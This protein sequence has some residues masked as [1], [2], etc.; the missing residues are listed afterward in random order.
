MTRPALLLALMLSCVVTVPS[1]LFAG[2]TDESFSIVLLPD[3][4]NYSEKFPDTYT[5]Q[6][7]WIRQNKETENIKF[8][9][10]LGDVVQTAAV[11]EQWVN[12]H[13]SMRL[14]DGILPYSMVPGNHDQVNEGGGPTRN[15]TLYNK[16]FGPDRFELESWYGGNFED[17]NDNN[18]V[19]FEAA[20][21]KFMVISLEFCPRNE[22]LRWAGNVAKKHPD[23]QVIMATHSY[24]RSDGRDTGNVKSY[25][26]S[27]NTGEELWEKF[28]SKH[29]NVFMVVCGH[30]G[31]SYN[32]TST[33]E[34]GKPVHEILV[35]YQNLENGGDGWLRVLEFTPSEN[36]V[37]AKTYS[38]VVN[39]FKTEGAHQYELDFEMTR[40]PVAPEKEA[41][42][43][44]IP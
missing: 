7:V 16:Y 4:Q 28:V 21:I 25:G 20:G 6:T 41:A 32:Q 15:T 1:I 10:H 34:A 31:A 17:K 44:A 27:G 38:P 3:T 12:A 37:R 9:I 39:D 42:A 5:Q 29:P 43:P 26:L 35:D 23:H 14:L 8:V 36:K 2:E 19:F 11:E 22:V 33:N 30:I 18:Y 24:L 13:K 40:A